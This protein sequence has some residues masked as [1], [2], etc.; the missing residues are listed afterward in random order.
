M[1]TLIIT[2]IGIIG[3]VVGLA[4]WVVS[5]AFKQSYRLGKTEILSDEQADILGKIGEAQEVEREIESDRAV[6]ASDRLSRDW[7]RD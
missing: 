2:V 6:P 3:V 7:S 4:L 1:T 5:A